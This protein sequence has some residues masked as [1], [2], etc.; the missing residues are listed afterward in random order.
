MITLREVTREYRS[1]LGRTVRAVDD[2]SLDV[3]AGEVLGIAGPNGAGKTT[4][5]AI[6]LGFLR[7]TSGALRIDGLEPRAFVEAHGVAYV[8][9]LM[10]KSFCEWT[11]SELKVIIEKKRNL[12]DV[13]VC[14]L[15]R[16]VL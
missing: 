3:T 5:L 12:I 7:P 6:L 13:Q 10:A 11:R 15:W 1:L 4:L 14:R 8:P 9:E 2:V 16:H